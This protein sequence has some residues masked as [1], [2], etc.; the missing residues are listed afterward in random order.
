MSDDIDPA[1]DTSELGAPRALCRKC[2]G[3]GERRI[4]R[5]AVLCGPD[6]LG[7]TAVVPETCAYCDGEGWYEL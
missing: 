5:A 1:P 6:Y 4:Q 2:Y 3:S 7:G